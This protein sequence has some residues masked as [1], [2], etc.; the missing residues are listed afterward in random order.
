[1]FVTIAV[2]V[3][4]VTGI[5]YCASASDPRVPKFSDDRADSVETACASS[6]VCRMTWKLDWIDALDE[7]APELYM[8]AMSVGV[9]WYP[10]QIVT[11]STLNPFS[12]TDCC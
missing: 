2:A 7:P 9:S 1:M 3:R 11:S 6:N 5:K 8:L 12:V 10:F 4:F